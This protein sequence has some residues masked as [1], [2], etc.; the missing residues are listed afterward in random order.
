MV[1]LNVQVCRHPDHV[2]PEHEQAPSDELKV[3]LPCVHRQHPT[4]PRSG[5]TEHDSIP[6]PNVQA[7]SKAEFQEILEDAARTQPQSP[8]A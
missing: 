1:T 3:G 7:L 6:S 4:A 2:Q 5:S 8:I